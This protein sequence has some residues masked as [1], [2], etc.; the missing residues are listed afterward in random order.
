MDQKSEIT[1]LLHRAGFGPRFSYPEFTDRKAVVDWLFDTSKKTA[2][3][4]LTNWRPPPAGTMKNATDAERRE[5]RELERSEKIT[6]QNTL[7]NRYSSANTPLREK[8]TLFWMGHFACRP[9]NPAF[10]INYYNHIHT[11]ALGTF[12]NLLNS[13]LRDAALLQYLNN[14]QNRKGNPN[15][16]F[17]RELLEL[18]TLGR[19]NYSEN[20]IKEGARALTG[21]GFDRDSNFIFREQQ[22]DSGKKTFLGE[23]GNYNGGDLAEIILR[24]PECAEFITT[25]IFRFFVSDEPDKT[26]IRSLSSSFVKSGYDIDKL[27]Q[28]IF[29]SDW[30]YDPKYSGNKIKSPLELVSGICGDFQIQF[31]E[32]MSRFGIQ[33]ILGQNLFDPPNVAGWP[34]GRTWIDSSAL[35]FRMKLPEMLLQEAES[36]FDDKEQFDAME[37]LARNRQ[38]SGRKIKTT[39]S[40][41]Q[42]IEKTKGMDSGTADQFLVNHFLSRPLHPEAVTILKKHL[43]Q[44]QGA[45]R[46]FRAAIHIMCLPEYQLC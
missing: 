16:N 11:H 46:T 7:L 25:K 17:A 26:M 32:P 39:F 30:F 6:I 29:T 24:Q 1:H 45:S 21:W 37:T 4:T 43:G 3:L 41:R 38:N 35:I 19:G 20:D 10:T 44:E 31:E 27:F 9:T 15:E 42:L 13:M 5:Y 36:V 34:G 18:F 8:V 14:N 40:T 12:P 28:N 23:T 22:H 33:R 2:H